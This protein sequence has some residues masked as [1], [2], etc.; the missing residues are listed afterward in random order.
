MAHINI[1]VF[2]FRFRLVQ[3]VVV[4][5]AKQL[6]PRTNLVGLVRDSYRGFPTLHP[7]ADAHGTPPLQLTPR[8]RVVDV[9]REVEAFVLPITF[10]RL[11]SH[12]ISYNV[13]ISFKIL[14]LFTVT[15]VK[16]LSNSVRKG[17]GTFKISCKFYCIREQ[18]YFFCHLSL[19]FYVFLLIVICLNL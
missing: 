3:V 10:V 17:Y 6:Q 11:Y 8:A 15:M 16:K 18:E 9:I 1:D 19:S 4:R 5:M 12:V 7:T 14:P 2:L 13:L